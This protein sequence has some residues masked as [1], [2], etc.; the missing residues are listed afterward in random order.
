MGAG[1]FLR[2]SKLPLAAA[3]ML[4]GTLVLAGCDERIIT[5]RD[6]SVPVPKHATWAWRPAPVRP[7]P[8]ANGAP[9]KGDNRAVTSRDVI[10]PQYGGPAGAPPSGPAAGVREPDGYTDTVRREAREA[11]ERQMADKGFVKVEDPGAAD[12]LADYHVALRGHNVTVARGYGGYPGL[13]CGP[14]GCWNSWGWGPPD[15]HYENIQFREGMFVFD[16]VKNN[17][18]QLAYRATGYEPVHRGPLTQD[19]VNDMIHAL[20]KSLKGR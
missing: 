4:V 6:R 10:G 13:V 14:F 2:G 3:A 18:N 8:S 15:I 20:L 11:I 5:F 12:F 1:R 19:N 17:G 16:F 7:A 9:V